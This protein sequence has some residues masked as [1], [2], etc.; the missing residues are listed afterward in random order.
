MALHTRRRRPSQE[1]R[2]GARF[3]K[4]SACALPVAGKHDSRHAHA[5]PG[6]INGSAPGRPGNWQNIVDNIVCRDC[7][8][9][10][11]E[12]TTLSAP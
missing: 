10:P 4:R 1:A 2:H 7:Q 9:R 3:Q 5:D 8:N 12:G 6:T 11:A